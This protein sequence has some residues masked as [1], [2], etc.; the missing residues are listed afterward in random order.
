M[1]A[2]E[3]SL[4]GSLTSSQSFSLQA[5]EAMEQISEERVWRRTNSSAATTDND[6]NTRA[7]TAT[8]I[9]GKEKSPPEMYSGATAAVSETP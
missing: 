1:L 4:L 2:T 3:K 9:W 6:A 5:A 8:T 7:N